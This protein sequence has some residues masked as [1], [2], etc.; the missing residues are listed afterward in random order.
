MWLNL[1]IYIVLEIKIGKMLKYLFHFV[2]PLKRSHVEKNCIM[3]IPEI[4]MWSI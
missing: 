1:S 2:D 3:L 4:L